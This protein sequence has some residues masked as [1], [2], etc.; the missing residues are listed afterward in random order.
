MCLPLAWVFYARG[1][2]MPR[3]QEHEQAGAALST[4][5]RA[6]NWPAPSSV[7]PRGQDNGPCSLWSQRGRAGWPAPAAAATFSAA[8]PP[9]LVSWRWQPRNRAERPCPARH[10]PAAAA[11]VTS[12]Q[13]CTEERGAGGNRGLSKARSQRRLGQRSPCGASCFRLP[14]TTRKQHLRF[15][16]AARQPG[17]CRGQGAVASMSLPTKVEDRG[18]LG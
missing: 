15:S 2:H 1:R 9:P 7:K 14:Q 17:G 8:A 11:A 3:A 6:L 4:H 16:E 10:V 5:C 12:S 18:T 13:A